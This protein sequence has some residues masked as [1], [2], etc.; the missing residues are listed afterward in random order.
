MASC[1]PAYGKT[2]VSEEEERETLTPYAL[3]V[4]GEPVLKASLYDIE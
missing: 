3:R 1:D 2:E 4:L